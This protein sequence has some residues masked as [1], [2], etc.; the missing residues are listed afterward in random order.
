M[1]ASYGHRKVVSPADASTLLFLFLK[2][3]MPRVMGAC[4]D[5]EMNEQFKTH[6]N[7]SLWMLTS[8][9]RSDWLHNLISSEPNLRT[10]VLRCIGLHGE[11]A[12]NRACE[13]LVYFALTNDTEEQSRRYMREIMRK[14]TAAQ[15]RKH[16]QESTGK[17]QKGP[18]VDE[19]KRNE[20]REDT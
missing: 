6:L 8:K 4:K 18:T 20:R 2:D 7:P 11:H 19:S 9:E 16:G 10:V 1:K 5:I 3:V 14:K 15:K 17:K 12:T 13:T